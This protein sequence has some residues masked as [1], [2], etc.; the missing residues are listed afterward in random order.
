MPSDRAGGAGIEKPGQKRLEILAARIRANRSKMDGNMRTAS[1]MTEAAGLSVEE[2][3]PLISLLWQLEAE[4]MSNL[5]RLEV[6]L[7]AKLLLLRWGMQDPKAAL[8]FAMDRREF[9]FN[10]EL[11]S[12]IVRVLAESDL[13]AAQSLVPRLEKMVR[14]DVGE[15][16]IRVMQ[17]KDP[18][19]A[20][21]Y[22]RELES[23]GAEADVLQ[24]MAGKDPMAA[25]AELVPGRE[26]H[27][28]VAETIAGALLDR[29]RAAFEE[30]AG[31]LSDPAL[32]ARARRV[33][34]TAD[35]S[36]DPAKAARRTAAWLAS[37][38]E[39]LKQAG[40]LPVRIV[41]CWMDGETNPSA[42]VAAWAVSLPEGHARDS[43]IAETGRTWAA[44]DP[45][46]ASAWLASLPQG[47]G[48]DEAVLNL[49]QRISGES[50]ADALEWARTVRSTL[51]S[52]ALTEAVL[53]WGGKDPDAAEKAVE[54][55]P[56]SDRLYLRDTLE[57]AR[58]KREEAKAKGQE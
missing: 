40:K 56:A 39:A 24:F 10:H 32:R 31:S 46:G 29:D 27:L 5:E 11:I 19:A 2:L 6:P 47:E 28:K 13:P 8:A 37:E 12:S 4:S 58:G 18:R 33:A 17:E 1:V 36:H 57:A 50:P 52:D 51:R 48:R 21:A 41:R 14:E 35:A 54:T 7:D 44:H 20:L 42:D 34:L 16:L 53:S 22:A 38:P 43:A 30:W 3:G 49:V 25:A 26:E 9:K 55:L 23:G 15:A 45:A